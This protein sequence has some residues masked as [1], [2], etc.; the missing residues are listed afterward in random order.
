MMAMYQAIRSLMIK[1]KNL[2]IVYNYLIQNAS[3][4]EALMLLDLNKKTINNS[5]ETLARI[6][7]NTFGKDFNDSEEV[8]EVIPEPV[9]FPSAVHCAF[10]EETQIIQMLK[11]LYLKTDSND[12]NTCFN[13]MIEQQINA[14]RVI[15]LSNKN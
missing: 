8:A 11:N 3:T 15:Y 6:Y 12:K 1:A 7:K 14:L 5:I 2:L 13:A 9:D 4:E 10:I